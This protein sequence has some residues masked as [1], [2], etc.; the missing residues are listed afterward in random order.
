MLALFIYLVTLT[1]LDHKQR[2]RYLY[3][4]QVNSAVSSNNRDLFGLVAFSWVWQLIWCSLMVDGNLRLLL[5]VVWCHW[6]T[7]LVIGSF[8]VMWWRSYEVC[9]EFLRLQ[10]LKQLKAFLTLANINVQEPTIRRATT[11]KPR[12]ACRVARR[13]PLFSKKKIAC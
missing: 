1:E 9:L 4:I 6:G 5:V 3:G 13:K 2:L 11:E 10:V 7:P 12:C 8:F